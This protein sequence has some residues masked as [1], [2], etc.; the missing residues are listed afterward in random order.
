MNIQV[1]NCCTKCPLFNWDGD[2]G[3]WECK[4]IDQQI[5]SWGVPLESELHP[6]NKI[7]FEECPLKTGPLTIELNN[8]FPHIKTREEKQH[9]EITKSLNELN[10]ML[11]NQK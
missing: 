11:D 9:P 1:S 6:N 7:V 8:E 2:N 10:S 5:E 4:A 3:I